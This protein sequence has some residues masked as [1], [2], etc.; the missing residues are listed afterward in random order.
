M[1]MNLLYVLLLATSLCTDVLASNYGVFTE[2]DAG[3]GA[4][5]YSIRRQVSTGLAEY[6]TGKK[7]LSEQD[8]I[9]SKNTYYAPIL[10]DWYKKVF[11]DLQ[12]NYKSDVMCIGADV[13]ISK[14]IYTNGGD[15][16][17]VADKL[18]ISQ[19]I[20]TRVYFNLNDLTRFIRYPVKT[21]D[22]WSRQQVE[23][24]TKSDEKIINND[25]IFA[26]EFPQGSA[27]NLSS[28]AGGG[29]MRI[30]NGSSPPIFN[31]DIKRQ[32]SSGNIKIFAK[33]IVVSPALME[34]RNQSTDLCTTEVTKAVPFAFQA[35]GIRGGKGGVGS[36]YGCYYSDIRGGSSGFR[37]VDIL[38][39][40]SGVNGPPG[41]GGNAGNVF[42]TKLDGV[43][44]ISEAETLKKS[45]SVEG[46]VSGINDVVR[47]FNAQDN[48]NQN[49][50]ERKQPNNHAIAK[51]G[52]NGILNINASDSYSALLELEKFAIGHDS[53]VSSDYSD[54]TK[55][56][57]TNESLS[58]TSFIEFLRSSLAKVALSA[59]RNM[60]YK[61]AE[62]VDSNFKINEKLGVSPFTG[63][64]KAIVGKK[65]ELS[66]RIYGLVQRIVSLDAAGNEDPIYGYFMQK[67]GVFNLTSPDLISNLLT[68]GLA[69]DLSTIIDINESELSSLKRIE[70]TT[71]HALFITRKDEMTRKV[72][73]IQDALDKLRIIANTH[74][75]DFERLNKALNS[76]GPPIAAL[77]GAINSGNY[78]LAAQEI[79]PVISGVDAAYQTLFTLRPN[80]NAEIEKAKKALEIATNQLNSLIIDFNAEKFTQLKRIEYSSIRELSARQRVVSR[81]DSRLPYGEDLI[82]LSFISFVSDPSRNTSIL[83]ENLREIGY[84]LEG[85]TD[86]TSMLRL[87][88]FSNVCDSIAD[89]YTSAH[90]C[91]LVPPSKKNRI[92]EGKIVSKSFPIYVVAPSEDQYVL[93]TFG[94]TLK[95]IDVRLITAPFSVYLK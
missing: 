47:T 39:Q 69:E 25:Y 4:K 8:A 31:D 35:A 46:G 54:L 44:T 75:T 71:S 85:K 38:Y 20:D 10:A 2:I 50:C 1:K 94:L 88:Q 49:I 13:V 30:G 12:E 59:E 19:P 57:R 16:I 87:K 78:L 37:C 27:I 34:G 36:P 45:T 11:S 28:G 53:L 15:F 95:P 89:P 92:Y 32:L 68:K 67:G 58:Y 29:P 93:P 66:P 70:A 73:I 22:A 81:L 9:D 41:N 77:I 6:A 74:P 43:F 90:R 18:T 14:P 23:Y 5:C 79:G 65:D 48:F 60:A 7:Y 64:S 80:L 82:K 55:R 56:A 52:E 72:S 42:L 17:I 91:I 40:N 84:W 24:Y 86:A 51:S 61:S 83:K 21:G 76:A 33:N 26:P 63:I 3:N 62:S